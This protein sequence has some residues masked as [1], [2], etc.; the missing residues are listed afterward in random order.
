MAE[1]VALPSTR[2]FRSSAFVANE[3]KTVPSSAP[4]EEPAATPSPEPTESPAP[5][6]R[7]SATELPTEEIPAV[8]SSLDATAAEP[9]AEEIQ[10]LTE[11]DQE[12]ITRT[13][14]V[15]NLSWNV[16]Q[17]WLEDELLKALEV[18]EGVTQLRIARDNQGRSRGFAFV[19][20][21]STELRNTLLSATAPTI[22]GRQINL[23][24]ANS[25]VSSSLPR[26]PRSRVAR[27]A[28]ARFSPVPTI[29]VGN[30]SWAADEL[31]VEEAFSQFG[32]IVRVKQPKDFDT[33]R[34]L[35]VAFVEYDSVDAAQRAVDA[36]RDQGI[37]IERRPVR[38]DFAVSRKGSKPG[39]R[40][41]RPPRQRSMA[42]G[43]DYDY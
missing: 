25:P 38:V 37:S 16:D 13:V 42:G 29:W 2:L 17:E 6:D 22:D 43:R 14:F 30:V 20:L 23:H 24:E 40:E 7:E 39:P 18:G 36:A 3:P 15:G 34:S 8:S 5:I 1:A 41:R 32:E 28:P 9:S 35:G 19:E 21:A 12:R 26:K 10:R 11:I 33:G 27:D 31:A 4:A